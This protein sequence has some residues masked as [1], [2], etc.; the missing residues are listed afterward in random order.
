MTVTMKQLLIV[1]MIVMLAVERWL[2]TTFAFYKWRQYFKGVVI[3]IPVM[4][5][6]SVDFVFICRR[7]NFKTFKIPKISGVQEQYD[8]LIKQLE[9]NEAKKFRRRKRKRSP[10]TDYF[11]F[12]KVC[13]QT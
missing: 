3:G 13:Y 1:I 10:L 9:D 2:E 12:R 11:N 5:V 8:S 4:K 7:K 6:K